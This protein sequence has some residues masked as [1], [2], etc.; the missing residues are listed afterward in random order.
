MAELSYGDIQRAVY[1]ST[2]ELR[3]LMIKI[4][5]QYQR[6]SVIENQISYMRQEIEG[7]RRQINA[8]NIQVSNVL[9][10]PAQSVAGSDARLYQQLGNSMHSI[11]TRLALMHQYLQGVNQYFVTLAQ[12]A[13]EEERFQP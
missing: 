2:R 9:N 6:L 11:E 4:S 1:E 3:E 5:Q 12:K 10:R 8:T 13:K 7:M